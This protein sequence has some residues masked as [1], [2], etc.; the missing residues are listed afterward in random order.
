MKGSNILL[1]ALLSTIYPMLIEAQTYTGIGIYAAQ[2]RRFPCSQALKAV[3]AVERPAISVLW[4][5]F[6]TST[7]CIK[8]FAEASA[9]KQHLIQIHLTNE[10]CRLR[11]T[12][13]E[14]ELFPKVGWREQNHLLTTMSPRTKSQIQARVL[15]ILN[16]LTP[17]INSN[18][19]LVLSVGLEDLY[20]KNSAAKII[21]AVREVWPYE[22]V[23][24]SKKRARFGDGTDYQELHGNRPNFEGG[25]CGIVNLDGFDINFGRGAG[26]RRALSTSRATAWFNTWK[27]QNCL[28]VF[29]WR[30]EWQG[31]YK[32][33]YPRPRTRIV[34]FSN[35]DVKKVQQILAE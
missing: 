21:S 9:N 32:D 35:F 10:T 12:C 6:G 23:R 26:L 27:A 22:L 28:A 1:I 2:H 16:K 7:S 33:R 18:T 31:I 15:S 30:G 19:K 14:G 5:T 29:L 3:S 8:K 20:N 17:I 24:N 34:K 11:G 25:Q 13:F 4:G